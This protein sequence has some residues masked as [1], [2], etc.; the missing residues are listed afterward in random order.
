MI[1]SSAYGQVLT[2][3]IFSEEIAAGRIKAKDL[4]FGF[5]I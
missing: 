1:K 4:I 2:Q 5:S 3:D